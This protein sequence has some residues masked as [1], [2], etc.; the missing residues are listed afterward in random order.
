MTSLVTTVAQ[1]N[2][3]RISRLRAR[4]FGTGRQMPIA[5]HYGE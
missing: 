2:G 3:E 5:A 4:A 1:L